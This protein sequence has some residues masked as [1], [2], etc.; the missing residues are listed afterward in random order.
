MLIKLMYKS[1]CELH[2]AHKY[3]KEHS[4]AEL[5]EWKV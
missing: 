1:I 3:I 4:L 2:I 5:C